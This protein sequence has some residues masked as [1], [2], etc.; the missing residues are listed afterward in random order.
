[1]LKFK[2]EDPVTLIRKE[3]VRRGK[4]LKGVKAFYNTKYVPRLPHPRQLISTN[5]HHLQGHPI[6]SDLFPREN[7]VGGTRRLPNLS[8]CLSPTVQSSGV[9]RGGNSDD[10]NPGGNGNIGG[11]GAVGRW[12]GSYHCQ[13]YKS[14]GRC[15]VC[16][17]MVETSTIT[18]PFFN[19]RFAIHGRNVHLPAS[20]K[21]KLSWFV[22]VCQD[23]ACNLI[24]VG[25]TVDVCS[26]WSQTKKACLDAN[27]NNTG[28][29]KH[30]KDGCPAYTN[31]GNL[32]HLTWTLVDH[33]DTTEGRLVTAGHQ[34]G[35]K[36]RCGECVRLKNTEDKWIC[37]LGA[38]HGPSGLNSRDEIKARSRV[39][40]V[41]S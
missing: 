11:G 25:S 5:Y 9:N 32:S 17:H 1:M 33:I 28:L 36:C 37:R 41:G 2:D 34:G 24:Y 27:S 14:K 31:T 4:P 21:K 39:N 22:Y 13:L 23:T 7:L 29:Y 6:L 20:Q 15:D 30:F 16:S 18:S 35:A 19:R 3:K 10:D 38:F 26:R 40:F 8:E 12:N